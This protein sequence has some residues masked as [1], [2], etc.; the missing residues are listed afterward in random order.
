M[1]RYSFFIDLAQIGLSIFYKKNTLKPI[2]KILF[3]L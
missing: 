3:E 2:M 1:H